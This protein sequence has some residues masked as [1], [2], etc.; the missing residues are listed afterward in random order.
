MTRRLD[1]V[2]CGPVQ[3]GSST[4]SLR[5][6]SEMKPGGAVHSGTCQDAKPGMLFP[7]GALLRCALIIVT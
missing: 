5:P 3:F 4:K 6:M 2:T 1:R 7:F